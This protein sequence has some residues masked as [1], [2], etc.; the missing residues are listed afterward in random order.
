M[1]ENFKQGLGKIAQGV[2]NIFKKKNK[3]PTQKWESVT[4]STGE[5][6]C[7]EMHLGPGKITLFDTE[8]PVKITWETPKEELSER[9]KR[10][11]LPLF[12]DGISN[13]ELKM[14]EN[15][16][17][18][19]LTDLP[20]RHFVKTLIISCY[21]SFDYDSIGVDISQLEETGV[22]HYWCTSTKSMSEWDIDLQQ[23]G[24]LEEPLEI[25]EEEEHIVVNNAF[26]LE[27]SNGYWQWEL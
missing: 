26:L 7:D 8:I 27:Y 10:A 19:Y 23:R 15:F 21:A 3:T 25:S 11:E 9:G 20:K 14:L 24:V 6:N 17:N 18:I 1:W 16:F 5:G 2:S 13:E 4:F 12:E 22:A